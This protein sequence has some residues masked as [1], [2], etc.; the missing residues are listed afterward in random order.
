MNPLNVVI[1]V[2]ALVLLYLVIF[3]VGPW[4]GGLLPWS[5]EEDERGQ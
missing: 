2:V 4:L 1:L 5:D 3:K